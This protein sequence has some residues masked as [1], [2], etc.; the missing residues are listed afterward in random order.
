MPAVRA[1]TYINRGSA[2]AHG[3]L[4]GLPTREVRASL[5]F[6]SCLLRLLRLG[7]PFLPIPLP[8]S[9]TCW[10]LGQRSFGTHSAFAGLRFS[11]QIIARQ[12]WS[13]TA[14]R[15]KC[16]DPHLPTTNDNGANRVHPTDTTNAKKIHT[17]QKKLVFF[18][19]TR[20]KLSWSLFQFV[21]GTF[22]VRLYKSEIQHVWSYDVHTKQLFFLL[23]LLSV[24]S[25]TYVHHGSKFKMASQAGLV[26]G[27]YG[28]QFPLK[29]V[30]ARGNQQRANRCRANRRSEQSSTDHSDVGAILLG[31]LAAF[32]Q[33]ALAGELLVFD[34]APGLSPPSLPEVPVDLATKLS[35]VNLEPIQ[36]V[37]TSGSHKS[38]TCY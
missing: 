10:F 1:T 11:L 20:A 28:L 4:V 31:C 32:P 25:A 30:I 36:Q 27:N 9:S 17:K 12:N 13:L 7:L 37:A 33:K 24:K 26:S 29:P 6:V 14:R 23:P 21:A 3:T 16:C 8:G 15:W 5:S 35:S 22:A 34:A 38:S 19:H 18:M 2:T